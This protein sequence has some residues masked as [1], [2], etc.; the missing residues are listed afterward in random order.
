MH[1]HIATGCRENSPRPL[2]HGRNNSPQVFC[3][4]NTHGSHEH[5]IE[6]STEKPSWPI[7]L[8][9]E[10]LQ[11]TYSGS[12]PYW[13]LQSER[14]SRYIGQALKSLSLSEFFSAPHWNARVTRHY[15]ATALPSPS[16]KKALAPVDVARTLMKVKKAWTGQAISPGNGAN[17]TCWA[18]PS[19]LFFV[20]ARA[21]HLRREIRSLWRP[22][23]RLWKTYI[24]LQGSV[25]RSAT[26]MLGTALI[27]TGDSEGTW[28]EWISVI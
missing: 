2:T 24:N 17:R 9:P 7:F 6:H 19:E 28:K 25:H 26:V 18:A 13:L 14:I 27:R 4:L 22:R 16:T 21:C 1:Q 23:K 3:E 10:Y 20:L 12:K 8:V 11:P 15:P 5:Q